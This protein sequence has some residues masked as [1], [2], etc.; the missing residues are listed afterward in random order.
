MLIAMLADVHANRE[1]LEACLLHA[2][3]TGAARL[4]FLGDLVGY[5]ADPEWV[6][7]AAMEEVG[8]GR[9]RSR[10][11]TTGRSPAERAG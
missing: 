1:A 8:R 5:G 4:V 10:A 2:R 6:V 11:T 3:A 9:W 7:G